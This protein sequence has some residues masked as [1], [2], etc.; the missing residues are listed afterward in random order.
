MLFIPILF[1][2]HPWLTNHP[3]VKIP[4]DLIVYKLV[5]A[6]IYSSSLRKLALNV[7]IILRL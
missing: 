3:D 5:R 2:G 6:Y 7:G 1:I 4:L